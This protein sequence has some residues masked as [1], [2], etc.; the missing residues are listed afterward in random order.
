MSG[1]DYDVPF[2]KKKIGDVEFYVCYKHGGIQGLR[3]ST[4]YPELAM[5]HFTIDH[6]GKNKRRSG[7][8]YNLKT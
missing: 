6:L 8:S 5:L 1:M 4:E 3:F 7:Y 2:P